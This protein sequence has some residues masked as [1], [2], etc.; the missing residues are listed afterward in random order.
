MWGEGR[1]FAVLVLVD[2]WGLGDGV[3]LA[4]PL[5]DTLV[6]WVEASGLGC[7]GMA[8]LDVLAPLV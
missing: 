6:V 2:N 4:L 7:L 8:D 3:G 1:V 5:A